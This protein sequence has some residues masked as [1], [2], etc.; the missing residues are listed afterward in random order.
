MLAA[1]LFRPRVIAETAPETPRLAGCRIE[2][3]GHPP[4]EAEDCL[5]EGERRRMAAMASARRRAQFVAGRWL[6]HCVAGEVFGEAGYALDTLDDRP[7]LRASDGSTASCSISHSGE[8]V[9]CAAARAVATGVDIELIRPRSN[10]N[11][12]CARVLHPR[13]RLRLRDLDEASAWRGFYELW[14]AK[15]AVAKALGIGLAFPF[16]ALCISGDRIEDAPPGY[17]LEDAAWRLHALD[18]GPGLAAALAWRAA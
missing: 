4:L 13:E 16:A 6:L 18:A 7:L 5:T 2:R 14:T 17:E 9:I 3:G 10:W 1:T 8:V 12:L 15:E 11:A